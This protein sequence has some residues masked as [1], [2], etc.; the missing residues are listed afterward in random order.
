M[1][2]GEATERAQPPAESHGVQE[3]K[4]SP[5]ENNT[6][7]ESPTLAQPP[8][9]NSQDGGYGWVVVV[10]SMLINAHTYGLVAAYGVVLSYYLKTDY[11]PGTTVTTYAFIGGLQLSQAVLTAPLATYLVRVCGTRACLFTGVLFQTLSLVTSSFAKQAYQIVLSEGI[12]YG[13][14]TGFLFVGNVAITSQ[15]F[16]K[17]RSLANAIVSSGTGFG[18]LIYSLA[19][20]SMIDTIGLR[21]SFRILAIVCFVVN[22][23]SSLLMRDRNAAVGSKHRPFSLGLMK[24]PEFLCLQAWSFLTT[25]GYTALAFSVSAQA[26]SVGLSPAQA[27]LLTSLYNLGQAIGRPLIGLNADRFGRINVSLF[28]TILSAVL[29]F[30]FWMPSPYVGSKMGLL[31]FFYIVSGTVTGVFWC[32]I[33]AVT[34]EVVGL[35]ELPSALSMIWLTIVP[36][37]MFA[38]AITLA[39]KNRQPLT[40]FIPPQIFVNMMFVGAIIPMLIVRGWKIAEVERLRVASVPNSPPGKS[41]IADGKTEVAQ[42]IRPVQHKP[43]SWISPRAWQ[44][45]FEKTRV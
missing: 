30:A 11:F 40:S 43:D 37:T 36:S 27:S 35:P 5:G 44:T 21:W 16:E 22:T 42:A 13:W 18:A 14:G 26:I 23:I 20:Q 3:T 45:I 15:W 4:S 10:C 6:N 33:A 7:T 8:A 28:A 9:I 17:K 41:E 1:K 29:G 31:V 34:T 12:C 38:E 25:M 2:N 19:T 24:K 32:T 39:L